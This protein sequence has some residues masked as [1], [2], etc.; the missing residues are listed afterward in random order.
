MRLYSD[1]RLQDNNIAFSLDYNIHNK[2]PGI[3]INKEKGLNFDF[4]L[5]K[6][7]LLEKR[8]HELV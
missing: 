3:F 1:E 8:I 7:L 6:C 5:T 2:R 4:K